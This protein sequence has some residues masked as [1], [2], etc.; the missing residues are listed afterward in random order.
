M[1]PQYLDGRRKNRSEAH[2]NKSPR[3][4][5]SPSP[6]FGLILRNFFVFPRP[7]CLPFENELLS[8]KD[9]L[10]LPASICLCLRLSGKQMRGSRRDPS[11]T[12]LRVLL[13]R[14]PWSEAYL[15][16]VTAE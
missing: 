12:G 8:P 1:L 16:K 9:V 3:A 14:G 10:G 15:E 11:F 5:R 4:P 6:S 2:I 13:P 7:L